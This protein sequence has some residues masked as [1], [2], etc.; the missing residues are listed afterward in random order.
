MINTTRLRCFV[1]GLSFFLPWIV[2]LILWKIPP[3]ISS[4]YYTHAGAVFM[5]IL[6]AASVLLMFYDGYDKTDDI[7]NTIAG[8][9]GLLICLFP[10]WTNAE[11]VGTFQ[12][13]VGVSSA[14][15]NISAVVFFVILAY[16]SLFQFT[17]SNGNMTAEKKARNV[18]YRVCGCGMIGAFALL[19]LPD[20][21]I[22]I[23]LVEMIALSFFGISWLT[24]ANCLRWLFADKK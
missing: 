13:P 7:L 6:G 20:F 5:I 16:V 2:A 17:K 10:C 24:K 22:K 11:K 19:L 4:T 1:G 9:F 23:W 8:I 15:H 21:Y 12:A 18:I 14:I 3:S